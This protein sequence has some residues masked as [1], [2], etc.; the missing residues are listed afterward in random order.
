MQTA[1]SDMKAQ[2][3]IYAPD[4]ARR[5]RIE[6]DADGQPFTWTGPAANEAQAFRQAA[7]VLASEFPM[8][9]AN[10]VRLVAC[11]EVAP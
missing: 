7:E 9:H 8:V 2:A 6:V 5:F 10:R 4:P 3:A 1:G 11:V